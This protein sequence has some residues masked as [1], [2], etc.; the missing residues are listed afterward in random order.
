MISLAPFRYRNC[1]SEFGGPIDRI[2]ESTLDVLG[3]S[4]SHANAY[5]RED[6][7]RQRPALTVYSQADGS[8]TAP[9]PML[10]RY[11]SVSEALERWAFHECSTDPNRSRFGFDLDPSSNGMAAYPGFSTRDS[12]RHA[13]LEAIER[14]CLI[15]W[16]EGKQGGTPIPVDEHNVDG[17]EV[18]YADE[19]AV[20]AILHRRTNDGFHCYGYGAGFS[21]RDAYE[22]AAVELARS[23]VVV[24]RYRRLQNGTRTTVMQPTDL[25]ERRCLYFSTDTGYQL[26][27][28]ARRRGTAARS[29]RMKFVF[30]GEI[31][32]AWTRY[33]DV[34]RV[35]VEPPSSGFYT[36][37]DNYFF[38]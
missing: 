1:L 18:N 2:E 32:G 23:E 13:L 20:V 34:W 33:A 26:F 25:F 17:V 35:A 5:L 36:A 27:D 3:G 28:V 4:Q 6:L 16:W 12:R 9:S 30:D 22:R 15:A 29:Q 7:V 10:A 24:R 38:W 11:K 14:F 37:G 21:M 8:G 31:P 19:D